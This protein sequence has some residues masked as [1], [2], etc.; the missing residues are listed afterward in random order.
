MGATRSPAWTGEYPSTSWRYWVLTNRKPN[1]PKKTTVTDK[2]AAVKRGLR[3]KR[4]SSMG[5]L[6]RISTA[7]KAASTATPTAMALTVDTEDQPYTGAWMMP[8]S[9]DARPTTD[10]PAP[11][12]SSGGAWGSRE[13]GTAMAPPVS[14][15]TTTG[16]LMRKTDPHQK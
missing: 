14:A 7:A 10:N 3:K 8:Y 9:S 13:S 6:L 15:K 16:T 11:S 4:R 12:G 5:W 2:L 1:S